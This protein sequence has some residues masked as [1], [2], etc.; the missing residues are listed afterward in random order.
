MNTIETLWRAA[1]AE[2]T[3]A[4]YSALADECLQ[5]GDEDTYQV[6]SAL[7][8]THTYPVREGKFWTL[9]KEPGKITKLLNELGQAELDVVS[10]P[11]INHRPAEFCSKH[12]SL[13]ASRLRDSPRDVAYSVDRQ[14]WGAWEVESTWH[15]NPAGPTEGS[16]FVFCTCK[17]PN[18]QIGEMFVRLLLRAT[19][20]S[21]IENYDP[22]RR[23]FNIQ[24]TNTHLWQGNCGMCGAS[25]HTFGVEVKNRAETES[26]RMM[27]R[28]R[29]S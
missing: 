2:P 25:Y 6:L 8:K 7:A 23:Q 13:I 29:K 20:Q 3:E 18:P 27:Q 14:L 1:E 28:K 15:N 12:L 5:Q 17:L 11:S 10:V 9:Q 21:E 19:Y 26:Y 16:Y 4:I 24:T 22:I